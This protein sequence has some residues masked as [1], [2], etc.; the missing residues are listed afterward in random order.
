MTRD[1]LIQILKFVDR[2]RAIAEDRTTLS[3]T[4]PRWNI[5]SFAM[6]RHLEGKLITTSS[7]ASAAGV[8]YGTAMRRLTDLIEEGLLLKRPRSREGKR[9]SLHPS[10]RLI[11]EFE[12]FA[13]Q[14][15]AM[16]G[17]TFGFNT[18]DKAIEDFYFGGYYM[19]SRILS[20]PAAMR[21]G[22]GFDT[23][24][25]IL[26]P[27]D[28]TFRTLSEVA[29]NLSEL[30]GTNVEVVNLP[31]G[32]LHEEIVAHHARGGKDYDIIAIDLPWIG[33]LASAGII[34]PIDH[35]LEEE[36]FKASDF[37]NAAWRGSSWD[38]Q[39][40]GL[41]IQPTTELLF[42]RSDLFAEA[43]LSIPTTTDD[44]LL[45]ARTLHRSRMN[46]A[47]I[48]MNFG[49]GIPVAHSFV[50]TMADFGQP[51]INLKSM[52]TEFD[53]GRIRGEQFR[54]M[55]DSPVGRAT[56]EFLLELLAYSHKDSLICDWDRRIGIFTRG[57]AAMTYGW[58]IR[59][60]AFELDEMAAA[61]GKVEFVPHPAGPGAP[62]VSPIGGF[63]LA[64]PANLPPD[65][66]RRAWRAM[67][68]LTRPELIKWYVQ[69]GNL[70]SPRFSTSADPEVLATS[71]IIGRID[72][73]ER[74]GEIQIWPRPPIPEFNDILKVLGDRIYMMLQ[75]AV[76]IDAALSAAQNEIDA[77]M[78]ANGRY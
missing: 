71:P 35:I 33:Q 67:E 64:I 52:G 6:Q 57:H 74:R 65:R 13:L 29:P 76:T 10:R 3:I 26:S 9:Y 12:A 31:L 32:Q 59:A 21:R 44:V 20:T 2:T 41:P 54:P 70:S 28:P 4:D 1:E 46:L 62:R 56:A 40:Y 25:R 49:R 61:H 14:L 15:K 38:G 11:S 24:I 42:C 75:G 68:Y 69:K 50:Q 53:V 60:G 22:V 36:A 63:S 48:V 16:V 55:I 5:I 47:G 37:H 30:C 8:P 27:V 17:Q 72:E 51:V 58:S 43:G 77:I 45:A 34:Q 18:S 66:T 73:M 78:R 23:K 7:A 19:A 39:H